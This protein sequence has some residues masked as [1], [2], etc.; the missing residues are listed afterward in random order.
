LRKRRTEGGSVQGKG[1]KKAPHRTALMRKEGRKSRGR[2]AACR[3]GRPTGK[4][5]I[6]IKKGSKKEQGIL[7]RI[8][9][10]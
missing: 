3:P 5:L 6:V 1:R 2:Q 8:T 10:E 9:K 7:R 4:R